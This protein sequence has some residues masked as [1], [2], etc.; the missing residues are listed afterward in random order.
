MDTKLIKQWEA[1]R[2]KKLINLNDAKKH[3]LP[4]FIRGA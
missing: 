1:P 4:F 3:I 2:K